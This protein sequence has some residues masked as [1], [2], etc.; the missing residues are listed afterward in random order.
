MTH[1]GKQIENGRTLADYNIERESTLHLALRLLSGIPIYVMTPTKDVIRLAAALSD[2]VGD[3][4][5]SIEQKEGDDTSQHSSSTI[6]DVACN[7]I[8]YGFW[9]LSISRFP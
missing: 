7:L 3:V 5:V 6:C 2:T 4:K 9:T 1:G 8:W